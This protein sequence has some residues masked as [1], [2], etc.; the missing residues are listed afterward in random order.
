MEVNDRGGERICGQ[1]LFG[2]ICEME[3]QEKMQ[4]LERICRQ[5]REKCRTMIGSVT[6]I[7]LRPG[8][9]GRGEEMEVSDRSCDSI[10]GQG[11]FDKN[12]EM[13]RKEK[14]KTLIGSVDRDERNA[15][16]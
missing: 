3:R 12:C 9:P 7:E 4:I 14:C 10:S 8:K 5:G 15:D 1:G 13:K 2:R 6:E 11:F 16:L